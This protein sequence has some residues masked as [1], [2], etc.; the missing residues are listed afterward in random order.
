MLFGK[1][2][3]SVFCRKFPNFF[4]VGELLEFGMEK[5]DQLQSRVE[6]VQAQLTV[7]FHKRERRKLLEELTNAEVRLRETEV[8]IKILEDK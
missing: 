2:I 7:P 8:R 1:L 3:I 4:L 6:T 5:E